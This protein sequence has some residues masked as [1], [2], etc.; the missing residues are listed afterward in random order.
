MCRYWYYLH[1][2]S[3]NIDSITYC[4]FVHFVKIKPKI[5]AQ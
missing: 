3:G 2:G 1:Y 5:F 4:L